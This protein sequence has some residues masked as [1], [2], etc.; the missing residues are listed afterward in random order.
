MQTKIDL[1][2]FKSYDIRGIYPSELNESAADEPGARL[3]GAGR[4][5]NPALAGFALFVG[6][7]WC[8]VFTPEEPPWRWK[9]LKG[10]ASG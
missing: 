2:I 5:V 8:A 4:G 9:Q 10:R 7:W 1:D 3:E 6:G